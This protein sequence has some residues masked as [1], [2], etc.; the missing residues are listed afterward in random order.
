MVIDTIKTSLRFLLI[1]FIISLL[2]FIINPIFAMIFSISFISE[3]FYNQLFFK[4]IYKLI[5]SS[6]FYILITIT[7]LTL[8]IFIMRFSFS[9]IDLILKMNNKHFFNI[10]DTS[11]IFKYMAYSL[12]CLFIACIILRYFDFIFIEIP[13]SIYISWSLG[14][15]ASTKIDNNLIKE[16]CIHDLK[17]YIFV[18]SIINTVLFYISYLIIRYYI[19]VLVNSK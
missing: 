18:K 11:L 13:L 5:I 4:F 6:I 17:K 9:S 8:L 19:I 7:L 1:I 3:N 10:N 14:F 12:T 15:I 2:Y 16:L